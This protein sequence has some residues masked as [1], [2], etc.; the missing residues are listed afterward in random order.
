MC[1][2]AHHDN[3]KLKPL[4]D[5]L[6]V[7]LFG[8]GSTGCNDQGPESACLAWALVN[9]HDQYAVLSAAGNESSAFHQLH[10]LTVSRVFINCLK[11]I[12]A[13]RYILVAS[14]HIQTHLVVSAT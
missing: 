12:L 11:A 7:L 13:A 8:P 5:C 2:S 10:L 6:L 3:A 14:E 4:A 1:A 9:H